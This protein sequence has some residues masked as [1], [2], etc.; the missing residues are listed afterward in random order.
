MLGDESFSSSLS[1]S[2]VRSIATSSLRLL[3]FFQ[4][5]QLLLFDVLTLLFRSR[6]L[7]SFISFSPSFFAR[8]FAAAFN[9]ASRAALSPS[10]VSHSRPPYTVS[11]APE[12]ASP[13]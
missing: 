9:D 5:L 8:Y 3:P 1:L 2:L 7:L 10:F 13:G 12:T 4:L 11:P 6:E